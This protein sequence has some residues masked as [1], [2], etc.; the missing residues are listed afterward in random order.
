[1]SEIVRGYRFVTDNLQSENGNVQWKVG[2]WKK[3]DGEPELCKNG[4]HAS[5]EPIDSLHYVFGSRWFH[6]EARGKIVEDND[7]FAASKMRLVEEIPIKVLQRFA[8][9]CAKHVYKFW[10]AKYPN[11]SRVWDCIVAAE[12]YLQSPTKENLRKLEVAYTAAWAA[13]RTA[14]GDAAE[15][16]AWAAGDAAWN[17]A[18]AT[19]R[20]AAGAAARAARDARD[21]A[22]VEGYEKERNWQRRK[23][24]KLIKEGGLENALKENRRT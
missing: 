16:A 2:E 15:N 1:M 13:A 14:T 17:A 6:V 19:A 20:S 9:A 5:R 7:K 24:A 3:N 22:W 11:D 12:L 8:I 4:L 23:L 10:K 18:G 21:A